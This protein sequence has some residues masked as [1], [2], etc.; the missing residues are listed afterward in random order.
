MKKTCKAEFCTSIGT[1]HKNGNY[2]L[3]KSL[4]A[5]HYSRLSRHGNVNDKSYHDKRPAIIRNG[6]T[7]LEIGINAKDGY[8]I[9]DNKFRHLEK[10]KWWKSNTGYAVTSLR[11]NKKM[12][13]H[14]MI[15]G[16]PVR[17]TV[18]D[19]INRNKLDNRIANLRH[20][21]YSTNVINTCLRSDNSTGHR[22][23]YFV[24]RPKPW[25]A[26]VYRKNKVVYSKCFNTL[27]DAV[28][29]RK[30]FTYGYDTV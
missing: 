22:G 9:I 1:K 24:D 23:V 7:L 3:A 20:T 17:P 14:H 13:L 21:D 16:K 11:N 8:A 4:C 25:Y 5:K 10:Y 29:A 19:H 27:E 2:Y 30:E 15:I 6:M 18:T 26:I 28:D 12:Y